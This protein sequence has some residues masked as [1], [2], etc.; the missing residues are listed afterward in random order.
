M[1]RFPLSFRTLNRRH[2]WTRS[3]ICL[4]AGPIQVPFSGRRVDESK[5]MDDPWENF[6]TNDWITD[7]VYPLDIL[8]SYGN[9]GPFIDNKINIIFLAWNSVILVFLVKPCFCGNARSCYLNL[10]DFSR[11]LRRDEPILV[12]EL[13]KPIEPSGKRTHNELENHH[14]QWVNP[15][16]K[17]PCSIAMSVITR[18]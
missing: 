12:W 15:R 6:T 18:G 1:E 13:C 14:V 10:P 11:I 8:D 16:T 5:M 17:W 7:R 3:C 2:R 4:H 9:H